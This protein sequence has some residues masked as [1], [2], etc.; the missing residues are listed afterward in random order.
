VPWFIDHATFLVQDDGVP[1]TFGNNRKAL[2]ALEN[3]AVLVDRSHWG[4]LRLSGPDRLAFLHGQSTADISPMK[5]GSGTD[6]V[7]VDAQARTVDLATCLVQGEGAL[8]IVSPSMAAPVL[9]RLEKHIF[10]GDQVSVMDVSSKTAMF[11]ILG[12]ASDAIMTE[13]QAGDLVGA[14]PGTHA[15]L[16]FGGKPVVAFVGGGLPGPGYTLIVEESAAAD[17]WRALETKAAEPMG[18]DAWE[19][20][21]VVAGRPVPGAELTAEYNPLEAGLYGA[22]SLNKGCYIGQ[23]ALAKVHGQGAL[24]R[25]LWGLVMDAPCSVGDEVELEGRRVIVGG[26]NG[27]VVRVPFLRR[28]FPEGA[29]P[30]EGAAAKQKLGEAAE[31]AARREEKLRAMQERLAAWQ[32]QQK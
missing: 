24:R 27:R 11:S 1:A 32:A 10:M 3:S 4:R 2:D 29:A 22:V 6:T 30:Q 23:E 14:A 8:L 31:E 28:T 19:V 20:A 21:R 17:L 26:V 5:P 18:A 15:V 16:G 9:E 12:P 25:E 13:L 7:L